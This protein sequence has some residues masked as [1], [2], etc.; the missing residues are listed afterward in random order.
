MSIK[1]EKKKEV[2]KEHAKSDNDTGSVEIQ[3][4]ILT[5]R[6]ENLIEQEAT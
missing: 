5:T 1:P 3:C 2:I 6:I 4:A